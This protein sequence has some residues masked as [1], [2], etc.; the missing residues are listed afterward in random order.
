[1][2]IGRGSLW[3]GGGRWGFFKAG[4]VLMGIF[5]GISGNQWGSVGVGGG[6]WG[7]VGMGVLFSKAH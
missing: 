1:M 5:L 2:R 6:E 4:W 7:S 3:L